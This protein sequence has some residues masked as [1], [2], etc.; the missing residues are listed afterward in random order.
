MNRKEL[1]EKFVKLIGGLET[2]KSYLL[3]NFISKLFESL[4]LGQ[5]IR[6][7]GLGFFHKIKFKLSSENDSINDQNNEFS[8]IIVFTET[9]QL[10]EYISE[11]QIFWNPTKFDLKYNSFENLFSISAGK[12]FLNN[13]F[14]KSGRI[15]IPVSQNEYLDLIDSKLD[16][17][18]S[19]SNISEN[20]RIEIPCLNFHIQNEEK[21]FSVEIVQKEIEKSELNVGVEHSDTKN[22]SEV[23]QIDFSELLS[24][25]IS[26]PTFTEEEMFDSKTED[27]IKDEKKF[28]EVPENLNLIDNVSEQK[29]EE[30]IFNDL[31]NLKDVDEQ[32]EVISDIDEIVDFA[33]KDFDSAEEKFTPKIDNEEEEIIPNEEI[34]WDKI[35]SEIS[36]DEDEISFES[37]IKSDDEIQQIPET[38]VEENAA[39]EIFPEIKIKEETIPEETVLDDIEEIKED[40]TNEV[41]DNVI[42]QI[43]TEEEILPE[44][45]IDELSENT[46]AEQIQENIL[47]D[48]SFERED[49]DYDDVVEEEDYVTTDEQEIFTEE[50]L[51]AAEEE[52]VSQDT[53]KD[54]SPKSETDYEAP[55]KTNKIWILAI[56]LIIALSTAAVYYLFPEYFNLFI[57]KE[58]VSDLSIYD[59]KVSRI[60]RN[61]DLPVT[62]PYP[63]IEENISNK[64]KQLDIKVETNLIENSSESKEIKTENNINKVEPVE[65]EKTNK[66]ISNSEKISETISKTSDTY[67]VQVASFKSESIAQREVNKIKSKGYSAFVERTEIPNRGIWYRV[68]VSGF[69]SLN[70]AQNFQ[71]KYSKGDI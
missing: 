56:L 42:N 40:T 19:N 30:S 38:I 14:I 69:N 53:Q 71:I 46:T 59:K 28:S 49:T 67:I 31:L 47:S 50:E 58:V 65:L 68:K 7:N 44:S 63:P 12:E 9:E 64:Q 48:E 39:E 61:F 3:D 18:L 26:V 62:Y 55:Q 27:L 54:I 23:Q 21:D 4:K 52:L 13:D 2:D 37:I 17:L 66:P 8:N 41:L 16:S 35:I 33:K 60:E 70:E 43:E 5:K 29:D 32:N 24:N 1:Q 34:S 45:F 36:S 57:Q 15:I 11:D 22:I 6:I 25:E 10:D 51:E 20:D